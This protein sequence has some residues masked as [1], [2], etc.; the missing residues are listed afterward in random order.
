MDIE[1]I[2]KN[3]IMIGNEQAY[4]LSLPKVPY[5][6]LKNKIKELLIDRNVYKSAIKGIITKSEMAN[7]ILAHFQTLICENA[8][9]QEPSNLPEYSELAD[10]IIKTVYE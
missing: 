9:T 5:I 2:T 4:N 6:D 8:N 3:L 10:K 7:L 1:K